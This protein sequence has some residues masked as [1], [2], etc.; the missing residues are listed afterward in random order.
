[1]NHFTKNKERIQ[2]LKRNNSKFKIYLSKALDKLIFQY[3][4]DYVDFKDLCRR[5]AVQKVLL[6]KAFNIANKYSKK[7]FRRH[8][9][10]EIM[11]NQHLAEE[12]HIRSIRK[13]EKS[14]VWSSFKDNNGVL[15]LQICN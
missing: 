3:D 2:K 4:M 11:S 7:S 1:M 12:L 14:K 8:V 6:D 13:F 10:S 15:I 9:K 5:T